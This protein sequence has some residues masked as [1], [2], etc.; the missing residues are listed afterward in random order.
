VT[1]DQPVIAIVGPTASGKSAIA[2]QIARTAK[3]LGKTVEII[4][5]DSALVYRG[6][7]I[8]T[9]KP[10]K[11]E[12]QEVQHHGIDIAE[13]EDPYSAAKFA[14][15]AKQ[16]LKEIR[17]RNNIPLIVGGTMLYWRALAHG[18]SNMPPASPEIR[19]EIELRAAKL[20]WP[21]IHDELRQVDP[22]TAARLEK[23]DT[24][25]VQRALEIYLQSGKP[26]SEWLQ[27]Q[28]KDTGRG[29]GGISGD[30][31][32][33]SSHNTPINLR[34]I[35]IEPSDRS[36]L[37]DR[38]AK[39]FE[40]MMAEGFLDEMKA[41]HQNQRLHPDLPSMRAVG[42]RQAW[43]YLDGNITLQEFQDQAIAATR[44]LAKRQLTWLRGIQAKEVVDSLD[45]DQMKQCEQDVLAHYQIN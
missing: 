37:H 19:A 27:E 9:A 31:G 43:D 41:L 14:H 17:E 38:I 29:D 4:S 30:S 36:V 13:P 2:M 18:L 45:S 23:N 26:M 12:M 21:A 11:A 35:S 44:Q 1:P 8:G 39:R 32:E 28:P 15:D 34:L 20:G 24:Q 42:Y 7:D 40:I 5:M 16:W 6:M 22:E 25:R 33:S 10:S 3:S